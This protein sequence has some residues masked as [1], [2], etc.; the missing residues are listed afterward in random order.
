MLRKKGFTLVEL[1]AIIAMLGIILAI[2]IPNL[3]AIIHSSKEKAFN[4]LIDTF[5]SDAAIYASKYRSTVTGS[6]NS[7]GYYEIT[8]QNL[9]NEGLIQGDLKDPRTDTP[10]FLTK[11]VIVTIDEDGSFVYCYEDNNCTSAKPYLA[12]K[13]TSSS[14][15]PSGTYTSKNGS[16]YFGGSNPYNWLA[17]G[18][19]SSSNPTPLMWRIIKSDSEGIKIIYEGFQNGTSAPLDNGRVIISSSWTTPW[20]TSST[21]KWEDPASLKAKLQTWYNNLYIANRNNYVQ[22]IRW[23]VGGTLFNN[24]TSLAQF[25]DAE[26]VNQSATGGTFL[27]QTANTSAV[28]LIKPS[29]YISTSG[30]ATCTG[31][32]QSSGNNYGNDCG[33]SNFLAK[34]AYD[35]WTL[36]A[37]A[38][39]SNYVYSINTAGAIGY[40]YNANS[41]SAS[42]RPVINLKSTV[43]YTSGSGTL[44]DPYRVGISTNGG[45]DTV[46]PI[47][48]MNGSNPVTID[49]G[50]TYTDAGAIAT[51][52]LDGTIS[53]S[54]VAM[55][56]VNVNIPGTYT[57]TYNVYDSAGNKAE[58]QTRVVNVFE[59]NYAYS[60]TGSYQNFMAPYTGNYQI[61]LWGAQGG[62]PTGAKGAYAKGT[63]SLTKSQKFYVYIGEKN[64]ITTSFNGGTAT[65]AGYPGG[66]ASDVRLSSGVWNDTSSLRSRIIVAGGGGASSAG[67]AGPGSYGGLFGGNGVIA[68]GGTQIAGGTQESSFGNGGFGYGGG[69]CGG[70]GGYYGGGGG[71]C[72]NGGGGGS[73][74]ISGDDRCNAVDSSGNPTGQSDHYS[75][76]VFTNTVITA[77]N[78]SMS[79]PAGGTET[80]HTGNGYGKITYIP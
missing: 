48:V 53:T 76:Y 51:D 68:T 79:A 11:K 27:G 13:F 45:N 73:S 46:P 33:T 23:C 52:D 43:F 54:I 66:G 30:A 69:G 5:E 44:A 55:G 16:N 60:F 47:I 19:A 41:T 14:A 31:S 12:T 77:G 3:F 59:Y 42:V 7:Q 34:V 62:G 39:S 28:G 75:G 37:N 58:T 40:N 67:V 18:Q 21:N 2:A 63:I 8:L 10:I 24:P 32:Y 49:L 17:F 50:S 35:W 64:E 25:R 15:G 9:L 72:G 6:I 29:D 26:C 65:G 78:A 20:N 57:I 1:L 74:F 22:P 71:T 80:G 56:T 4:A 38:S 70:G 61:E 36:N